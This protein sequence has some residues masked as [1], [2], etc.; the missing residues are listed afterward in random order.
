MPHPVIFH[1][2]RCHHAMVIALELDHIFVFRHLSIF[3]H[4]RTLGL[5]R[6]HLLVGFKCPTLIYPKIVH[7]RNDYRTDKAILLSI[8][9]KRRNRCHIP[10]AWHLTLP[11]S[12]SPETADRSHTFRTYRS[13]EHTSEL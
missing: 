13:E 5:E 1:Y 10:T 11:F 7:H 8:E 6:Q 3:R 4:T 12:Q 9:A 2:I